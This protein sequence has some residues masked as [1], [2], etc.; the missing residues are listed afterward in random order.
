MGAGATVATVRHAAQPV[1]AVRSC[2]SRGVRTAKADRRVEAGRGTETHP[3]PASGPPTPVAWSL[4]QSAW[5][6]DRHIFPDRSSACPI[7]HHNPRPPCSSRT[8][9]ITVR[10]RVGAWSRQPV[11]E[12]PAT[13]SG[14]RNKIQ[15][16]RR[17]TRLG[18]SFQDRVKLRLGQAGITG[19]T[20]TRTGI[21][22]PES[23]RIVANR[24]AGAGCAWFHFRDRSCVQR[25]Y[26]NAHIYQP[27]PRHIRQDV[28]VPLDHRAFGDDGDR[29]FRTRKGPQARRA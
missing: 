15:L 20:M 24:R 12:Q 2:L 7:Q 28:D 27:S 22:A 18:G 13:S 21:P 14:R 29:M 3:E 9:P 10:A 19:A 5:Q 1:H 16:R 8:R 11:T 25:G 6:S 17:G 26:R 4:W 23:A